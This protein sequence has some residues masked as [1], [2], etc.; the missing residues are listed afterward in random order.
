[1]DN[2]KIIAQLTRKSLLHLSDFLI[3]SLMHPSDSLLEIA[4][5]EMFWELDPDAIEYCEK[6]EPYQRLK[7]LQQIVNTLAREEE[8]AA[9]IGKQLALAVE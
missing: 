2:E 8:E 4:D 9:A 6:L 5:W 7:F 1:M 3:Q